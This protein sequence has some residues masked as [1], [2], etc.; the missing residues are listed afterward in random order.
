MVILQFYRQINHVDKWF[1]W[2]VYFSE[3]VIVST[4]VTLFILSAVPCIPIRASWDIEFEGESKCIDSTKL[5]ESNA[6]I[7]VATDLLILMVPIPM[8]A[9]LQMSRIRKA[10]LMLMFAIG[11]LTT[12]TSMARLI[13]LMA[14]KGNPDRT[15]VSAPTVL[16]MYVLTSPHYAPTFANIG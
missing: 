7:G 16:W 9:G 1:R 13:V 3:F 15:W 5:F 12:L 4:S 2:S 8:V 11:G 10:G 14:A 6:A